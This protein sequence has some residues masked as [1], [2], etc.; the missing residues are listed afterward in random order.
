[1][2]K[3][4]LLAS[5]GLCVSLSSCTKPV[6]RK[7]GPTNAESES[8]EN[9]GFAGKGDGSNKGSA[10]QSGADS[11]PERVD[12]PSNISGVL[13]RIHCSFES[14][15][16]ANSDESLLGCRIDDNEGKRRPASSLASNFSYDYKLPD[17]TD[18]KIF[19]RI[20]DQDN[21]YDVI[22]VLKGAPTLEKA[23]QVASMVI[24]AV[25]KGTDAQKDVIIEGVLAQILRAANSLP[26]A[27]KSDY[28]KAV[29]QIISDAAQGIATPLVLDPLPEDPVEKG[30]RLYSTLCASCHGD[31]GKGPDLLIN[32][33]SKDGI[34]NALGTVPEMKSI[35][36]IL[37]DDEIDAVSSYLKS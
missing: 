13:L 30:Q 22:Y 11:N 37:S 1:M 18:L 15:A 31:K 26:E 17:F 6:E 35:Q 5:L 14:F 4:Y 29:A 28:S 9:P 32:D 21:R 16:N 10:P 24:N 23:K 8:R 34:K 7:K 27:R 3:V 19:P 36:N 33:A 2:N 20:I 12:P 25:L